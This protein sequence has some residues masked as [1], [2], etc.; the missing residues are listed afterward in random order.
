MNRTEALVAQLK[1][2]DAERLA[3]AP[4]DGNGQVAEAQSGPQYRAYRPLWRRLVGKGSG[5]GCQSC[6]GEPWG[7]VQRQIQTPR[8][9]VRFLTWLVTLIPR[10]VELVRV[11]T[12]GGASEGTYDER[13]AICET[14][15]VC[16]K[17][18]RPDF[19]IRAYCGACQCPE[20]L[21]SRLSFKNRMA[22]W[23]CPRH[24]HPGPYRGDDVRAEIARRQAEWA[25]AH[26]SV[27]LPIVGAGGSSDGD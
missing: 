10:G 3:N 7:W 22:K 20:W 27:S 2:E 6:Q 8:R 25:E 1:A 13:Q 15:E 4:P 17:V 16:V 11:L 5:G 23:E 12:G 14:C 9:I 21:L 26:A 24:L 18:M 19:R